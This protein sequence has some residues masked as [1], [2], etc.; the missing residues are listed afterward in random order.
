MNALN[1]DSTEIYEIQEKVIGTI[2]YPQ[3]DT[4]TRKQYKQQP[5][6]L[7]SYLK[8]PYTNCTFRSNRQKATNNHYRLVHRKTNRCNICKNPTTRRIV[9]TSTFTCTKKILKDICVKHVETLIHFIA[10]F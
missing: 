6:P 10:N 7:L 3:T 2:Y 4:K 8:C 5:L 9:S 1:S